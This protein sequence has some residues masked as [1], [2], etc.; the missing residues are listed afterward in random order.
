MG[1]GPLII[2]G[3]IAVVATLGWRGV[4]SERSRV[5]EALKRAESSLDKKAPVTLE[6]DPVTGVYRAPKR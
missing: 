2:A 3:L 1:M 6:K 4:R 5:A